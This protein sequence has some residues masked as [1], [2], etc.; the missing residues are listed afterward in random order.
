MCAV[1]VGFDPWLLGSILLGVMLFIVLLA[2]LATLL[3]ILCYKRKHL[4][5]VEHK[6]AVYLSASYLYLF[7]YLPRRSIIISC[8]NRTKMLRP[9]QS[10]KTKN[11]I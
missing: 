2:L 1:V 9:R 6:S 5:L 3:Y 8:G 11:K 10:C 4:L 7:D